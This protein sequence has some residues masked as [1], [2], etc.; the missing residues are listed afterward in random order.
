MSSRTIEARCNARP[1]RLA[2]VLPTPDKN[3]LLSVIARATLLEGRRATIGARGSDRGY[4][5]GLRSHNA[6]T[7]ERYYD[8]EVQQRSGIHVDARWLSEP[9]RQYRLTG[10][11]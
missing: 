3:L 8:S 7:G 1:T 6:D 5:G 2:F 10:A 4:V 9:D 11:P